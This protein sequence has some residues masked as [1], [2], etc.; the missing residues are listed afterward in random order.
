[1]AL[2]IN[3]IGE[4]KYLKM[5]IELSNGGMRVAIDKRICT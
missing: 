5:I 4:F 2:K 1:M 3:N